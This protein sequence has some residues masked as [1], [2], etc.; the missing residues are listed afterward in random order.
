MNADQVLEL[1]K[2]HN[3]LLE[4]HFLLS[5]GLHSDKFLQSE[6]IMQYPDKVDAVI[7]ELVVKLKDVE[8]DTIVSPAIGGIRFGYELARQMKKRTLFT[9]RV[10]GHMTLRRGF[11]LAKGEKVLLAEDVITTGK[12]TKECINACIDAGADVIG[13]TC[14]I[15][16]SGGKA[17]FDQPFIPLVQLDVKTYDPSVCPM[18]KEGTPAYKPGSRNLK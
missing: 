18:C 10:D 5:S 1:Y 2:K 12:S 16:R 4:G 13:V 8:F 6:L 11:S 9:E 14:L 15:D 17:E 7:A 3:A